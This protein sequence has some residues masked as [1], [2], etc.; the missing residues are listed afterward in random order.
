MAIW[1][2]MGCINIITQITMEITIHEYTILQEGLSYEY[3]QFTFSLYHSACTR[4]HSTKDTII[5]K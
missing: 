1:H 5:I 2:G 4:Y 3:R